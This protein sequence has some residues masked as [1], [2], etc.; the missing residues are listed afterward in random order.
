[1]PRTIAP[2]PNPRGPTE[3]ECDELLTHA[4]ALAVADRQPPPSDADR[5]TLRTELRPPFITDCRAG[6]REYQQ[7]GLAAKTRADLDA[8]KN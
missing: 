7:C 2:P 5:T 6:S 8:C 3:P 1:V 4:L